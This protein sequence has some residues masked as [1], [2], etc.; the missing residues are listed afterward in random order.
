MDI[1]KKIVDWL[2][3]LTAI[4]HGFYPDGFAKNPVK[5]GDRILKIVHEAIAQLKE[6]REEIDRPRGGP[7]RNLESKDDKRTFCRNLIRAWNRND[8]KL[9][10]EAVV[11]MFDWALDKLDKVS[12]WDYSDLQTAIYKAFQE[13]G[14]EVDGAGSD[15]GPL[16]F[17]KAE[18]SQGITDA[19]QRTKEA[20]WHEVGSFVT[21][22]YKISGEMVEMIPLY[23]VK[24][25][26]DSVGEQNADNTD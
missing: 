6:C 4:E 9:D 2:E 18:L 19:E 21:Y 15:A 3:E 24:Q 10:M 20:V 26:I 25:A 16:E 14:V 17:S 22:R 1:D 7:R 12:M 11:D 13:R 5:A 8:P 23:L